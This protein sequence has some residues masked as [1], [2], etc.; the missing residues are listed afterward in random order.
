M[1]EPLLTRIMAVSVIKQELGIPVTLAMLNQHASKGTGPA[2][3][4]RMG[5]R[6]FLYEKETVMTWARSLITP[7]AA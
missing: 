3:A 7:V 6:C 2:P 4:A 5:G 1:T